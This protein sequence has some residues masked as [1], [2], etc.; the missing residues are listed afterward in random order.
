M[1]TTLAGI[2]ALTLLAGACA[3]A[4]LTFVAKTRYELRQE[5]T[6]TQMSEDGD[7]PPMSLPELTDRAATDLPWLKVWMAEGMW[8]RDLLA[9]DPRSGAEPVF[10]VIR[11]EDAGKTVMLDWEER[12]A[13][14][15]DDAALAAWEGQ[16]SEDQQAALTAFDEQQADFV[17]LLPPELQQQFRERMAEMGRLE[18]MQ[19]G[20]RPSVT[21][22]VEGPLG[23]ESVLGLGC[24]KYKFTIETRGEE[25][26]PWGHTREQTWVL[27]TDRLVPP[28]SEQSPW[29]WR[30]AMSTV[31]WEEAWEQA[32]EGMDIP[33]GFAMKRYT[34][35]ED[36][37]TGSVGVL[38]AEMVEYDEAAIAPAVFEVP[39]GFAQEQMDLPQ[40]GQP[41]QVQP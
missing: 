38:Q 17:E 6:Q 4:D 41:E 36:L 37:I 18:E 34:I 16:T 14:I 29:E 40:I 31:G 21:V 13:Q 26:E 9:Q 2:V 27:L 32:T 1:R 30:G 28:P 24:T 25:P 19:Q 11:L 3:S 10:S 20:A 23:S 35:Q 7:G 8:R 5:G 33:G 15:S 12:V 22:E 39:V